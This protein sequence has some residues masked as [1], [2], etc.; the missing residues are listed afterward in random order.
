VAKATIRSKTGATITVEG[1]PEE[2][3]NVISTFENASVVGHAKEAIAKAKAARKVEKKRESASDLIIGLRE[4][5]F[6]DKPKNLGEIGTALE[7][8]GFL[9]P[10]T[11]LSGI[12]LGLLKK[13][14]LRRKK[15]EGKWVYGK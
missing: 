3:S 6:F 11:S 1:T 14:E 12:V 13:R 7:E 8:R 4:E 5:G 9:Y 15:Q 10:I 2:V